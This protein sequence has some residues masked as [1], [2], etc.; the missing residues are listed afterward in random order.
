MAKNRR[1]QPAAARFGPALKALLICLLIGG[2]GIGYVG[3]K[4][5]IHDLSQQ[6]SQRESALGSMRLKN[7]ELRKHL[8]MLRSPP[9]LHAKAAEMKL[10]L[11]PPQPA[12]I[13]RLPEPLGMETVSQE[14]PR[15]FD[16]AAE[17]AALP[18]GTP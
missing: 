15:R 7:A 14:K 17:R 4:K 13:V 6:I 3:L 11:V 9:Y 16:L 5:Q 1:N 2:A 10:G 12:Q 18:L 8:D